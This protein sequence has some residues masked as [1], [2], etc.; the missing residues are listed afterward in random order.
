MRIFPIFDH[1][2]VLFLP[3][4]PSKLGLEVE[5]GYVHLIGALDVHFG[6][7]DFS[8]PIS[9]PSTFAPPPKEVVFLVE[10][11]H[12]DHFLSLFLA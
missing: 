6:G 2:K 1:K 9:T 5:I 3:Y 12:F 4:L 8:A 11:F 10:L 7:L